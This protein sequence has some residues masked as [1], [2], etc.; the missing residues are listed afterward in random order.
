MNHDG[1]L[2]TL[3]LLGAAVL[4]VPLFQ[5]LRLGTVL[6]FLAAGMAI[7]PGGLALVTDVEQVRGLAELG[8]VFLL[9]IIGIELK[10]ARLWLMRRQVF[11]MGSAQVL[12]TGL[13]LTLALMALE[14]ELRVA[15][16]L[17]LGL[18]LSS[19]AFV[20]QLL[21]ERHELGSSHGRAAFAILLLQDM[22][23]VP[24]LAL[25]PLLARP[26]SSLGGNLGLAILESLGMVVAVILGGRL[27]LRPLLH[28]V[29]LHG[30]QEI[31]LAT[32]LLLVLGIAMLIEQ[33]GM[34]MA[35]GAFLAGL[36]IA[37]S[38]FRHQIMADIQPF[39]AILLGLFF[40]TVGMTVD[41]AVL[42]ASPLKIV[43]LLAALII[44]KTLVLWGVARLF[45]VG[46]LAARRT[47]L[48]L[49]QGGEFA[50]V[51]FGAALHAGLL[52]GTLYQEA[53]LVVA[54]SMVMTP[55]LALRLPQ[56]EETVEVE[57]SEPLE[58]ASGE[59]RPDVLIAGFG[60]MGQRIAALMRDAG[61]SYVAIEQR[62][63]L[64][65]KGREAG[66]AVYFGNAARADVLRSAGVAHSRLMVVAID[67]PEV[68]EHVV[69]EV[70]RLYPGLPIYARGHSRQRCEQLHKA[71][72]SGVAS[73]NLEASL[74]L[75]RFALGAVGVAEEK[76]EQQLEAY[77]QEY[78]G[79]L[80][81]QRAEE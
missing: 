27:F 42:L 16:L 8:V 24:L 13:V 2:E 4:I 53:L 47:A 66:Y 62:P 55:L 46:R 38:E 57:E 79:Y 25:V 32:A 70:H 48:L 22:A 14:L 80:V 31:F 11:G 63:P 6:G 26:E 18:A 40:M 15:L 72:A 51:L 20:L 1:L 30:S 65:A 81:R 21:T 56:R 28:R 69:S 44:I 49:A 50:F 34:S 71:G 59:E 68:V 35:M 10:P 5:Y 7:G 52:A 29:A 45:G 58:P 23:V 54:L 12:A 19:T 64:V 74:Q 33:A 67:N 39:R 9:F 36:L 3:I 61:V 75:A 73:E 60:R 17:G 77:R 78:Y 37:D 76:V 43:L 41:L